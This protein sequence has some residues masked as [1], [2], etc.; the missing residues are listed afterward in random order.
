MSRELD[1]PEWFERPRDYD[2][3]QAG[4]LFNGLVA[5]LEDSFATQRVSERD[6]QDSSEY[7]RVT[8]SADATA[9]GTR[10]VVCVSKFGSLALVCAEDPGAFLGTGEVQ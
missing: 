8:V 4:A 2:R 10:I 3:R 1:D 9:C 5:C 6:T 7:G